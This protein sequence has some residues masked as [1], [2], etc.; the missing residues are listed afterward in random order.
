[1]VACGG[2]SRYSDYVFQPWVA[3]MSTGELAEK[4]RYRNAVIA[5]L[6]ER[7]AAK[8]LRRIDQRLLDY[9]HREPI[10]TQRAIDIE[11]PRYTLTEGQQ[12]PEVHA[13]EFEV[14]HLRAAMA[15]RGCLIVRELFNSTTMTDYCRVID[16]A[17]EPA[18][19]SD[20][21]EEH[22]ARMATIFS[23]PPPQLASRLP[24]PNLSYA[25]KFH[26]DGGSAMCVESASVSEH[27]LELYK[28]VGIKQLVTDYL[29]EA[30]CL[31]ALKWVLR[32]PTLPINRNGWHQDGAFMGE[33]IN[34]L[35][36]WIAANRCGG[37]SGAP[38]MDL[39]P[40]RLTKIL[41]AGEG[42]AV[43]DWSVS[44]DAMTTS[45]SSHEITT[46]VFEAG[47][48]LIFDH[49]LLH[50]TQY[51]GDFIRPRYAIETWFFG[52]KN[53]PSNQVPLSW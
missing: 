27:L 1:M 38:G 35:N 23:N 44:D 16:L 52:S 53:F 42:E 20:T 13:S 5:A 18:K 21:Q 34:S 25:R 4:S 45:Q 15:S 19:H 37:E 49:F 43:F 30:P 7:D 3:T 12:V 26:R 50:R 28:S 17:M 11:A 46:P 32:R 29:G 48:A 8:D 51:G 33:G 14:N 10:Q 9:A 31:S 36:M 41:G 39:L 6:L 40:Q 24:E 22:S 47:D 2:M